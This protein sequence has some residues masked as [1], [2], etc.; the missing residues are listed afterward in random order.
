MLYEESAAFARG[1]DDIG[2]IPSLQMAITLKDHIP[3][4]RTYASVH[5]PLYQEV[6]E[7]IQDL[8][9][10]GWNVKSK[11]PYSA[12]VVCVRMK[13]GSLGLCIDYRSLNKKTVPDR[14]TLP[15]IQDITDTLGGY[16]WFPILD[17]GKAYHQ[18]FMAE[19]SRHMSAFITPWGLYEWVKIPFGLTNEP[20]A[21]QRSMEEM[22][23]SL[24]DDCCTPYLVDILCYAKTFEDHLE[25]LRRVL[26]ALQQHGVKLRP[27]KM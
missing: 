10:R 15:R 2:C 22:L 24:R 19:G 17:Q 5:K 18:G 4:Q 11:S 3:V 7:Y 16:S 26:N 23:E 25:G 14:H 20:A 1:D 6:K 8:L 27:K 21:F 12:P 13:D 9:A